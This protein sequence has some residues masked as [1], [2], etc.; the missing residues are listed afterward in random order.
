MKCNRQKFTRKRKWSRIAKKSRTAGRR[1]LC[2]VS[3]SG[4]A[5]VFGSFRKKNVFMC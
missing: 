2:W 1:A 3:I 5:F 4:L